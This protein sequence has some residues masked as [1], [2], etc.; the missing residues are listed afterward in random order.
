MKK[1]ISKIKINLAILIL[2]FAFP[3]ISFAMT[4]DVEKPQEMHVGD[5]VILNVYLNSEGKEINALEGAIQIKG[6]YEIKNINT[7]GS[8]FDLWPNKPSFSEEKIT[9]VGGATSGVFG[10]R[11][12]VF[13]IA[14]KSLDSKEIVFLS[15]KTEAFLND[16]I[17]TRIDVEK[18]E[19]SIS[20]L[21][22]VGENKN[23]LE[24]LITEDKNS[25]NSFEIVIGKDQGV[26]DGKYFASFN[27]T[28]AESGINR[29]E[30]MENNNL[31]VRTG[32]TYVLQDQSLKGTIAV[33]AIDN[34]GNVRLIQKDVQDIVSENKPINW[35]AIFISVVLLVIIFFVRKFLKNKK[36]EKNKL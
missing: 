29:Y 12:K 5:I 9:F 20:S 15:E 19:K 1:I 8:I 30:V 17:G 36:L 23:E 13:S 10:S 28:D 31:P 6:N 4:I 26:F 33:K 22:S 27:T 25:P 2:L 3:C 35:F 14:L 24:K 11:L 7:A 34:A 21:D 16:G 32:N 18:M